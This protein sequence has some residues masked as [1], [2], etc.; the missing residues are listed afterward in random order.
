[1]SRRKTMF[2][3]QDCGWD[4]SLLEALL[5]LDGSWTLG[6]RWVQNPGKYEIFHQFLNM[7]RLQVG[8]NK[9]KMSK[10]DRSV[11]MSSNG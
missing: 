5:S 9:K 3:N 11:A 8:I 10:T 6:L 2:P 7:M 4:H 1:M